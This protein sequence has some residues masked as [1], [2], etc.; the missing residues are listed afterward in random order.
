MSPPRY[1]LAALLEQRAALREQARRA[2][3]FGLRALADRERE[4][5][6]AEAA[7]A[8]LAAEREDLERHLYD[9]DEAGLLPIPLVERR[10][11]VLHNV[12]ERLRQSLRT[13][14]ESRNA[15]SAAEAEVTARRQGLIE[16]DRELQVAEKHHEAW[17]A[18][19]RRER[20]RKDERLSEEVTLARFAAEAASDDSGDQGGPR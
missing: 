20:A 3:A 17:R 15:V 14:E 9:P 2:V 16:A 6:A 1:P 7:C 10:T 8:A 19:W 5:A 13:A 4:R 18:E 11:G 12:E